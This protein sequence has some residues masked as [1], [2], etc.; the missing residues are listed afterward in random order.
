MDVELDNFLSDSDDGSGVED[1]GTEAIEEYVDQN[2]DGNDDY[3]EENILTHHG[4]AAAIRDDEPRQVTVA[5]K[6][7]KSTGD[8]E[9]RENFNLIDLPADFDENYFVVE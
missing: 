5:P 4:V 7:L 8:C 9:N 1:E 2:N 3:V 6:I